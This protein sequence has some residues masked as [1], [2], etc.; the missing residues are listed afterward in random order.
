MIAQLHGE[1]ISKDG[2]S[3]IIMVHGVGFRV[4]VPASVADVIKV[5]EATALFTHLAV[6]DDR[7]ELFG[8]LKDSELK[9]FQQLI[10]VRDVGPKSALAILSV[11][12]MQEIQQAIVNEDAEILMTV[13]GVG[14]KTAERI[15]LEL[16]E[17]MYADTSLEKGEKKQGVKL[18]V[19]ALMNLGYSQKE[20]QEAIRDMPKDF[21]SDDE[22]IRW[23]LRNMGTK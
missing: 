9:F 14:K 19:S 21:E 18:V 8:F 4:L 7:F 22:R 6:Y 23:V 3:L 16:K 15:I 12:N 13:Q 20:A 10:K 5:G 17:K 2:V 11:G 1:I